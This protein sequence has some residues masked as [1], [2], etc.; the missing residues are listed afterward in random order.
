MPRGAVRVASWEPF[1]SIPNGQSG[2][3]QLANWLADKRN[4]LTARVTVN[5]I[6]Q[7]LF[8]EGLV[9]SVDYFGVRGEAPT[10]PELL[11]HLATRFMKAG[12]SQKSLLRS[13]VLSRTYRLSSANE[14]AA[15]K[16]DPENK[17]LWRMNRQRLDAEAM[18][19]SM[20]AI[21]GELTR[22]SGGPA[23]VLENPENCGALALKGVNPPTYAHKLPRPAQEFERTI[24]L[25]V[26]R[27]NFAG[28]DRVRNFFDFVNPAQISGQRPQTV[29]PTQ[30]LFLLNND[31]LRKRSATL[32]KNV[33]QTIR[34][35]DARI[36]EIWLRTLG[37]PVTREERDEAAAFLDKV[38][39]ALNAPAA[40]DFPAFTELC[41]G[42]L[43]SNQFIFRL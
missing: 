5:R 14:S 13:L 1:P 12:W 25:P 39:A 21:S 2:R 40:N 4:P 41:H 11:D 31:L 23:L 3:A 15:A 36:D 10:H 35:R 38:G 28:P 30:A 32:A 37:R 34:D 18:R 8:G 33:T 22:E 26:F 17:L 19:D 42:L 24:Y 27:N 9:R 16:I 20:L 29:V 7:K 6:W 43:A